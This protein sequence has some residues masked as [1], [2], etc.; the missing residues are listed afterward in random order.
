V[1]MGLMDLVV[2]ADLVRIARA[3]KIGITIDDF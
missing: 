1:G 3:K 2:G